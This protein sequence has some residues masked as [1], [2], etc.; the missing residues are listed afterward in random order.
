MDIAFSTYKAISE[1]IY[2]RIVLHYF[3]WGSRAAAAERTT[4]HNFARFYMDSFGIPTDVV[5]IDARGYFENFFDIADVQSKIADKDAVGDSD[6]TESPIAYVPYRNSQFAMLLASVAEGKNLLNVDI[7]FGLNLS[8][9]MV[10]M[11]NSE[12]WLESIQSGVRY[13]GKD[14]SITGTYDVIAPYFPRTKTNM[15]KE[16]R[17]EFG[18]E[19]WQKIIEKSFSCYYPEEDGTSCGKCGSC[20]LRQ[21]AIQKILSK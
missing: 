15:L 21:K 16:F 8:E 4:L 17:E 14:F 18:V 20:I 1:G 5:I 2:S 19:V 3:D 9:G 6:E 10:F 11:V 12:G 7:L 13:G